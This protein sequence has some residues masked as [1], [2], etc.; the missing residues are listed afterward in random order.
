LIAEQSLLVGDSLLASAFI[1]YFGPFTKTYRE[2]LMDKVLI[3][4]VSQPPVGAPIPIT[5]DIE[6]VGLLCT[7]AEIAEYQT[8]G[9]L[10]TKH[11]SSVSNPDCN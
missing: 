5:L 9:D 7:D 1:S 2:H 6:A 3:P 4:L 11:C 10:L 8:Q